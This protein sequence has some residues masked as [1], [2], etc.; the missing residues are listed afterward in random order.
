MAKLTFDESGKGP[1][2][3]LLHGFP[4]D[5]R[6]WKSQ[7]AALSDRFRVITPDLR[8]FGR[9]KSDEPFSIEALA[10]DVHELLAQIGALPC[11]LGGLSMGGYAALAYVKKY[12]S[13]LRGLILIDTKADADTTEGKQGREKMIQLAREKGSKAVADQ[14]MPKMLAKD[15]E[16]T[17]PAA[18]QELRA[19][20]EACPAR[21]IEHA[22][23]AMRDRPDRS[24]ELADIS[25]ATLVIVGDQDAITPPDVA[26][27][28]YQSLTTGQLVTIE[29]AGHMACMEQPEQ[30]TR[31]IRDFASALA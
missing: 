17:R 20:M 18:A 4:L 5:A 10:D 16:K 27:K 30:V 1:P 24:G 6:V 25:V 23:A 2:L 11:V 21:T 31:A 15:A 29:G 12:A 9:S 14:M 26:T 7:R 13:D 3:V 22:L 28:M 8:G 19:I